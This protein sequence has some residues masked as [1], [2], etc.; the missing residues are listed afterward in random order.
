VRWSDEGFPGGNLKQE[1]TWD[2][3]LNNIT[4]TKMKRK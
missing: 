1:I 2:M 3:K 4:K